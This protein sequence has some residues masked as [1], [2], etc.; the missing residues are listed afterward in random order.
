M[1]IYDFVLSSDDLASFIHVSFRIFP[2]NHKMQ[3]SYILMVL[4]G[5]MFTLCVFVRVTYA[6]GF[7]FKSRKLVGF[8]IELKLPVVN[9]LLAMELS[10]Q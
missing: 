1:L 7:K 10:H 5:Y 3:I 4:C 6:C 9:S 8:V 2:E